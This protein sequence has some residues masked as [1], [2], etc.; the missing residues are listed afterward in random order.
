MKKEELEILINEDL[1]IAGIG[2]KT[3]K[4]KTTIR[5]W[6]NKFELETRTKD[7]VKEKKSLDEKKCPKCKI[8]K[9]AD[10]FYKR[11]KGEDLSPYCKV[12]TSIQTVDRQRKLKQMC[13]DY[14]GGKCI[15]CNYKKYN[16]SLDF[17]HIDPKEKD[18]SISNLKLT[19]FNEKI[20]KELDKCILVCSNCH[21]E[22]HGGLIEIQLPV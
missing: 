16:G 17:H 14:K 10:L 5:Y 1:S 2:K 21:G 15:F 12:C 7:I 18:F 22:I 9:T 19:T 6:L 11:R 4:S 20:K 3:N 13:I 8:E